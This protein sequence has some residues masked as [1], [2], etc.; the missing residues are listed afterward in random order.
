MAGKVH[1]A[2]DEAAGRAA[3]AID[4]ASEVAHRAIDQVA[5]TAIAAAD[6][7]SA[8]RGMLRA[9]SRDLAKRCGDTVRERPL[10]AIAGALAVGYLAGRLAR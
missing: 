10:A 5:D 4:H 2:V 7:V 9:R 3:P 1:H 6:R 8:G